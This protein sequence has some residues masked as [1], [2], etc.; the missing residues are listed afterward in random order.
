MNWQLLCKRTDYPKLGYIIHRL[1]KLGI[2]TRF[3]GRSFHAEHI[4][5]VD[6]ERFGEAW[7]LLGENMRSP[8]AALAGRKVTLDDMPDDHPLFYDYRDVQP[9]HENR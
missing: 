6:A 2:A 8:L 4:L 9:D 1:R 7:A 3:S 5:E